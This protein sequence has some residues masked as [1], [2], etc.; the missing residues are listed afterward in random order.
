[1][2]GTFSQV[3]L[4][5]SHAQLNPPILFYRSLYHSVV[6]SPWDSPTRMKSRLSPENMAYIGQLVDCNRVLSSWHWRGSR[7]GARL[8]SLLRVRIR[9]WNVK[10]RVAHRIQNKWDSDNEVAAISA[11]S[12]S[13]LLTPEPASPLNPNLHS[14]DSENQGNTSNHQCQKPH[15][16]FMLNRFNQIIYLVHSSLK[17]KV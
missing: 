12:F 4:Q 11:G 3:S 6:W 13:F 17:I 14:T 1:V 8:S 16:R 15:H 2:G 7:G 9:V 5:V 10:S